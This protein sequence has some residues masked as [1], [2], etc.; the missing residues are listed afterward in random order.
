MPFPAAADDDLVQGM[1]SMLPN[2][3]AVVP[4][5]LP[6]EARVGIPLRG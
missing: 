1:P 5:T 3:A 6:A 2:L 4:G